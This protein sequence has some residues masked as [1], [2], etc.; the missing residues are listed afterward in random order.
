[1]RVGVC[2]V[3]ARSEIN[4]PYQADSLSRFPLT[5]CTD[6]HYTINITIFPSSGNSY[7]I[8]LIHRRTIPMIGRSTTASIIASNAQTPHSTMASITTPM[9]M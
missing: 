6:P 4:T 2:G 7:L 5:I 9:I 8:E 1:M 3:T